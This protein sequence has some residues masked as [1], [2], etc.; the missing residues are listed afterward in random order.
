MKS[1]VSPDFLPLLP[2]YYVRQVLYSWGIYTSNFVKLHGILHAHLDN[3][4]IPV[5]SVQTFK[6]YKFKV[7]F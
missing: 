3:R 5:S 2:V 6:L 1:D 7:Q 4:H